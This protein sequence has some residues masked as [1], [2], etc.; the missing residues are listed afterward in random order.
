[1]DV[2]EHFD[3]LSQET[4]G[5]NGSHRM[6]GAL[7][8]FKPELVDQDGTAYPLIA[9][10]SD[11]HPVITVDS[12]TVTPQADATATVA[13][14]GKVEDA[15][16]DFDV[17]ARPR[18]VRFLDYTA[19][20]VADGA[21]ESD[22]IWKPHAWRGRFE[23][24]FN[25]QL[26]QDDIIGNVTVLNAL[27]N[28]GSARI[29]INSKFRLEWPDQG[30]PA[31]SYDDIRAP[32]A[33]LQAQPKAGTPTSLGLSLDKVTYVTMTEGTAG[34]GILTGTLP[35]GTTWRWTVPE[36]VVPISVEA[37]T[38]L[39][40]PAKL[41]GNLAI[42]QPAVTPV[43]LPLDL[44]RLTGLNYATIVHVVGGD[45]EAGNTARV[46]LESAHGTIGKSSESG[47][48]KPL[49]LRRQMPMGMTVPTQESKFAGMSFH[50]QPDPSD[51]T[52][53][54]SDKAVLLTQLPGA[55]D[56][57]V[58]DATSPADLRVVSGDNTGA[59]MYMSLI[60]SDNPHDTITVGTGLTVKIRAK[61]AG[62]I[63]SE[64]AQALTNGTW[65]LKANAD[66]G[67]SGAEIVLSDMEEDRSERKDGAAWFGFGRVERKT[68]YTFKAT[69]P[70]AQTL[71]MYDVV[72]TDGSGK[73]HPPLKEQVRIIHP[74]VIMLCIDGMNG[75][76]FQEALGGAKDG[77]G[78]DLVF[79]KA[80][81]KIAGSPVNAP[82]TMP[83]DQFFSP[84]T[85][86]TAINSLPTVT[87]CNWGTTFTGKEPGEHGVLGNSFFRREVNGS[88]PLYSGNAESAF[89]SRSDHQNAAVYGLSP[90]LYPGTQ[91]L[92]QDFAAMD[93]AREVVSIHA[94]YPNA[95][96]S[97]TD[98]T[99]IAAGEYG[100]AN[101]EAASNLRCIRYLLP[102]WVGWSALRGEVIPSLQALHHNEEGAKEADQIS[103]ERA[104]EVLT[105]AENLPSLLA[106][107]FPGPDNLGHAKGRTGVSGDP[108]DGSK[109][110]A[111]TK[112]FLM[113]EVTGTDA[114]L[115][116]LHQRVEKLGVQN[117]VI[118][119]A[120]SDHGLMGTNRDRHLH[121]RQVGPPG[122]VGVSAENPLTGGLFS[123]RDGANFVID[124]SAVPNSP[125]STGGQKYIRTKLEHRSEMEVFF[126][127]VFD[128]RPNLPPDATTDTVWYDRPITAADGTV[129][130]ALTA[131]WAPELPVNA[132]YSPDGGL[133]HIYVRE[134]GGPNWHLASG[135]WPSWHQHQTISVVSG[136][137]I[138]G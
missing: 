1:L 81:S 16:S 106:I 138:S 26:R 99:G 35:S 5:L 3:A 60:M 90:L 61:V 124:D 86:K 18:E 127:R 65:K 137:G 66:E 57:Q 42:Q 136:Q 27:G 129:V 112:E 54:L 104:L 49:R 51:P 24:R 82:R 23:L 44:T 62:W 22:P 132:I 13:I 58:V 74:L 14:L 128:T 9:P 110:L 56:T 91:T 15:V 71:G 92:F 69:I 8:V 6:K 101:E 28:E 108:N 89:D 103:G 125:P 10:I 36:L 97:G 2:R 111:V 64:A 4:K 84:S 107:Y 39:P 120:V 67:T 77:S 48:V 29:V 55:T 119:L 17:G 117:A 105:N 40:V 50:W 114:Q 118:W 19:P 87:W 12:I 98:F 31:A 59:E 45:E 38:L 43:S 135:I 72:W 11:P 85:T 47:L 116:L 30:L 115:K 79:G 93:N 102:G 34:S 25:M 52:V 63:P 70:A 122:T 121:P 134:Q 95:K 73:E 21:P 20:I 96:K 100:E 131:L 41:S 78:L 46:I 94:W 33:T 109:S 113:N 130:P 88:R 32:E 126:R 83:S 123:L 80:K 133:A 75:D 7:A 68:V 53:W 76:L 37:G